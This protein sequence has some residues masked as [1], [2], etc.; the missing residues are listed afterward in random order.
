MSLVSKGMVHVVFS[1]GP[2]LRLLDRPQKAIPLY[3]KE[4]D[5]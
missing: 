4:V 1:G 2:L 3:E 5:K